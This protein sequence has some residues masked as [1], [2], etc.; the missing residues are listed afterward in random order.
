LTLRTQHDICGR[1][2]YLDKCYGG[3]T[4]NY[5]E[6]I[7]KNDVSST[8]DLIND[9]QERLFRAKTEK[10]TSLA[11]LASNKYSAFELA[12]YMVDSLLNTEDNRE[13]LKT[14]RRILENM[15]A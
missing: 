12:K 5:I 10:F 14:Y 9:E 4:A 2:S 8:I 6:N 15:G 3:L 7:N 11:K 1:C 13:L